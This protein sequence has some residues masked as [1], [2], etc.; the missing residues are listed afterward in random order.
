[1]P[2][3]PA[4]NNMRDG[5]TMSANFSDRAR[6]A[7]VFG[8]SGFIGRH[9]VRALA[10]QGWRV[11][12]A[13]R[14]PDLAGFLQPLGDVGQIQLAQ[15]NLR[16]PPSIAEA[17][18]GADAAIIATGIQ[19]QSGR[20]N[21][22]AV[23]V[24]GPREIARA[25]AA[26]GVS[27]LAHVSGLGADPQSANG[28]IASKGRGDA[29]VR[30]FFPAATIL[31]PSVVFG[32]EDKFLNRFAALARAMPA[33]PLFCGGGALLQPLYVGDL[34]LG[35]ANAL[36]RPEAQGANYELGGPDIVTLRQTVEMVLRLIGRRRVLIPLPHG[37]SRALARTTEIAA[38][39]SL[40]LFPEILTTTVD[41]IELLRVDNIV[42]AKAHAAQ[43]DLA[44]LG[45]IAQG[46]EAI[47]PS[48][49]A[50]F[51]RSGQ[52]ANNGAN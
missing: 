2:Y 6:L 20:Q 43:R 39:I 13:V 25:A 51:R 44:A 17:L 16:Y 18:K 24:F 48:Y 42:S 32:P 47:A 8:G 33:L 41:Q 34:A 49:L 14:R 7:T 50:R 31:Q 19:S 46:M 28:Y 23:H 40:G 30:E 21:F 37:A 3:S 12:V 52:F 22:E 1:M 5:S 38:K 11:R 4:L 9:I 26:A 35:C 10:Q 15:A 45:V 36:N 27:A 29:A